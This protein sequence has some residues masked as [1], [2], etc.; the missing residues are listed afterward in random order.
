MVPQ[1]VSAGK[2]TIVAQIPQAIIAE[3]QRQAYTDVDCFT[4]LAAVQEGKPDF[5]DF[6]VGL[7]EKMRT[8]PQPGGY[9]S[10]G[11]TEVEVWFEVARYLA[12][13]H[14][15]DAALGM[16]LEDLARHSRESSGPIVALCRGW[17]ASVLLTEMWATRAPGRPLNAQP[18]TAWLVHAK[19]NVDEFLHYLQDLP[20]AFRSDLCWRFPRE[21]IRA[22][23]RR[24]TNDSEAQQA[25]LEFFESSTDLDILSTVAHLCG[26]TLRD[27]K[28]LRSWAQGHLKGIRK[29]GHFQPMGYDVLFGEGRPVE[30]SMLEACLTSE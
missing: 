20:T 2:R 27:R 14:S 19:A 25:I 11:Y 18:A 12:R 30:F 4:A 7:F 6:C 10:W 24:L 23:R 22:V 16:A 3:W 17:P 26:L 8:D 15:G 28:A 5:K 21:T 13:H 1:L 29:Q 9:V